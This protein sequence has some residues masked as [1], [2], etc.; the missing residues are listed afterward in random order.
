MGVFF[1]LP[2]YILPIVLNPSD[3]INDFI[4]RVLTDNDCL[5]LVYILPNCLHLRAISEFLKNEA[6][7]RSRCWSFYR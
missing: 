5:H 4:G 7:D 6:S 2:P 3:L 1:F